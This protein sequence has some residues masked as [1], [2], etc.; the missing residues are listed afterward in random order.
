MHVSTGT[1]AE[2]HK[3][4]K[5][6]GLPVIAAIDDGANYLQGYGFLTSQ[7][8]KKD[9][10]LILNYLKDFE[11][12]VYLYKTMNYSHRYPSCWR[13]KSELV[14]KVTDEWYIA[15]DRPSQIS[16]R[17]TQISKLEKWTDGEDVVKA[18]PDT[19]TLRERMR[20]VTEK[21]N[22]IPSFG[23]DREMDWLTNMHDW[24]DQ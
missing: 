7:N 17:K 18:P 5:K 2:D 6:I 19:R 9:P 14:W 4:G 10:A 1:G 20:G 21:I 16:N 22:W 13:C 24:L 15:M 23:L 12:G 11:G 8:A 3:F